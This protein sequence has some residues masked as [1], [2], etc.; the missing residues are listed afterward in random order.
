MTIQKSKRIARLEINPENKCVSVRIDT[1]ITEGGS[2]IGRFMD[3]R[4]FVPGQL[5]EFKDYVGSTDS[6]EISYL[7]ATWTPE[8][9]A[10]YQAQIEANRIL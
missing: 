7:N 9:I 3:R 10:A 5:Q 2:I 1:I 6:P 4:S 8:V